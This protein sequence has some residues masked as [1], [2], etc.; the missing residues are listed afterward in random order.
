MSKIYDRFKAQEDSVEKRVDEEQRMEM[1]TGARRA[2]EK[3]IKRVQ[4]SLQQFR[5]RQ[6]NNS[7]NH[8]AIWRACHVVHVVHG[9]VHIVNSANTGYDCTSLPN[10]CVWKRDLLYSRFF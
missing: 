10:V 8:T 1:E 5:S 3:E 4:V 7:E 9:M 2:Q 6:P